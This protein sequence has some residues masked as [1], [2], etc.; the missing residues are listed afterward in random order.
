[1]AG[2]VS[3]GG[4]LNGAESLL[5]PARACVP[6][7][8]PA[9]I[10]DDRIVSYAEL[11]KAVCR[12]GHA[13]RSLGIGIGERILIVADD[14]P[15]FFFLYLGALKIGAVPVAVSM[16]LTAPELAYVLTD[17]GA[18]LLA[19]DTA[20]LETCRAAL[21]QTEAPPRLIAVEAPADGLDD[22]PSLMADQ[23]DT[24]DPVLLAPD[25]MALWMYTSGTTGHPKAVVHLQ[26]TLPT[27]DRYLGPVYGVGPG[28]R[29]FCSSKLFFAFSLGHILLAGTRLGATMVLH[30]GWPSGKSIE[31]IITATRPD[32]VLSVPTLYRLLLAEGR[33]GND[34]F[35]A[36]RHY[37]SA[38]EKLPPTLFKGWKAATGKPILE[39]IGA[40]EALIMFIGNAPGDAQAG[41]IGRP[42]PQT[43]VRL[44]T[45]AGVPVNQTGV[46]GVLWVRCPS[47]AQ[48]YWHQPEKTAA[49]F[50]SGWYRTGDVLVRD[51]DG[52]YSYQG[53]D[54]DMLK[55]SGQWVS[56]AE[57]EERVLADPN[58]SEAAVVGFETAE[59]FTR[60]ALFLVT[61]S[62][63]LDRD[64]FE[65]GLCDA[66]TRDLSIYKCPRRFVYL[67]EMPKT[68]TGKLQRFQLRRIAAQRLAAEKDPS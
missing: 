65:N 47:I 45:H 19:S 52:C 6:P 33:A 13:L 42:F 20:F 29:I 41:S 37:I 40:T 8:T 27:L 22:L 39:G 1:M 58:V 21:A 54:D 35:R 63:E 60:L 51:T 32:V 46:P 2:D 18:R 3:N 62:P 4:L 10:A 5:A 66:L 16:R 56:P 38:G 23:P 50:Q 68:A 17:S 25:D 55:I 7:E 14:R 15:E 24:L 26:K 48:G 31:A 28:D 34:A 12:A 61:V 43:E 59:G 36:V 44:T 57:I 9:L 53:R 49:A 11:D 64:L 30:A 67:D